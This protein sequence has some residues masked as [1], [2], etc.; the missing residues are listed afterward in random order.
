M[1]CVR[2]GVGAMY[3]L[4]MLGMAQF[5]IAWVMGATVHTPTLKHVVK[6]AVQAA[7]ITDTA[8][9]TG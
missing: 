4:L 6:A 8:P 5:A 3:P 7:T 2:A 1:E 9:L